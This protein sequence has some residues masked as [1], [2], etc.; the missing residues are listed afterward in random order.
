MTDKEKKY[1][2]CFRNIGKHLF[3]DDDGFPINLK[4]HPIKPIIKGKVVLVNWGWGIN[5]GGGFI[6]IP[7]DNRTGEPK[8][9]EGFW[10]ARCRGRAL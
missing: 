8:P 4:T 7:Y 5:Y 2:A 10:E 9:Y 6:K 1:R 3:R